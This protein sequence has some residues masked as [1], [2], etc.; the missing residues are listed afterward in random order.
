[1]KILASLL[2]AIPTLFLAGC[3]SLPEGVEPVADFDLD[4]YMGVWYEIARTDNRFERGLERV[5]AE[6]SPRKDGG[7]RVVNR[8]FSTETKEWKQVEGKAYFARRDDEGF[9]KVSF[10]G[11]FYAS[12]CVFELDPAG[13]YAFVCG[14]SHDYLWLL[15][16]KP[17]VSDKVWKK[18]QKRGSELGFDMDSVLRVP[19]GK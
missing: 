4:E 13:D 6:Y 9:L 8:G 5:T 14:S 1:M 7:V 11:P 19:Q 12:Y 3:A 10:F 18:F 16:R 2:L 15:S 17:T